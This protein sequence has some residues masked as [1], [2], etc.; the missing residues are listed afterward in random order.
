MHKSEKTQTSTSETTK[1]N[2]IIVPAM[3]S[4]EKQQP[5]QMSRDG[6]N[7]MSKHQQTSKHVIIISNAEHFT[8]NFRSIMFIFFASNSFYCFDNKLY[9]ILVKI[10]SRSSIFVISLSD[11]YCLFIFYFV[12]I[13][14]MYKLIN[15]LQRI[16]LFNRVIHNEKSMLTQ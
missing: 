11:H 8:P 2:E 12:I 3:G 5:T 13:K 7:S 6:T 16:K 15:K 10:L 14:N 1:T 9:K 4:D